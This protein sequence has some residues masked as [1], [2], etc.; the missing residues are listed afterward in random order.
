MALEKH[1]RVQDETTTTGTGT[2]NLS[3][4]AP[5][6]FRTFASAV[7]SGATVRYLI[8]TTDKSEWE[9]GEGVFTDGSPDTLT[10]ATVYASS[11][12]GSLVNFS[13]G[14]K[15]VSLVLV[16]DDVKEFK[17]EDDM[18]SDSAT[19]VASQQ[20]IKAY[21]D[22]N[23]A[24]FSELNAPQGFLL[25]GK[26]VPSVSSNNLTV[27]LRTLAGTDPS[28][29]DPIYI[30]I[31]DTVRS[32]TSALS[33]TKNAGTNWCNAGS[34]ELATKEIDYFVY[35]G[36]NATDGVVIGFSRIPYG[37][38]YSDFSA[39]TTDEKYCAI[40]TITNASAS[41]VY[42]N[43]GRFA[44]TLSAGAGYTWSVPTFTASNLIQRPI[45]ETRWLENVGKMYGD[46]GSAGSYANDRD[47]S[48][49]KI[50]G[51]SIYYLNQRRVTNIGSWSSY[52]HMPV[53][54]SPKEH[55]GAFA[56]GVSFAQGGLTLKAIPIKIEISGGITWHN[57]IWISNYEWSSVSNNDSFSFQG[58]YE[59]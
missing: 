20:S 2:V 5:T 54:F 29:S 46:S 9:V 33:V 55:T 52:V 47:E 6:G 10:R 22:N 1:D 44:A 43:V 30:R 39:T 17:D 28:T 34:S 45:Y 36:Y 18:S 27:A 40:S 7:T 38:L 37:A 26:I 4:S 13:A 21:V 11:N 14:T 48:K 35:L 42:E 24:D 59:I 31:G 15:N 12:S 56:S 32:I 51:N 3:A 41:D 49:Y 50:S 23:S 58:S 16:S 19:A 57:N 25:N 8:E 53:P